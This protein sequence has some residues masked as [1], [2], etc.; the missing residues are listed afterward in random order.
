MTKKAIATAASTK[1][2]LELTNKSLF[3]KLGREISE[4][5]NA[6]AQRQRIQDMLSKTNAAV[7]DQKAQ[8]M[9]SAVTFYAAGRESAV[10]NSIDSDDLKE[11]FGSVEGEKYPVVRKSHFSFLQPGVDI[12]VTIRNETAVQHIKQVLL[13]IVDA[14][15]DDSD[16]AYCSEYEE[17]FEHRIQFVNGILVSE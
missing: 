9:C 6:V 12:C 3:K 13:Q 16:I 11:Y 7:R 8:D 15:Q 2:A 1:S 5:N 4:R 17:D 10:W 14:I